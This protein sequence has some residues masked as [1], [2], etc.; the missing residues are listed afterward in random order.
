MKWC[1]P[2]HNHPPLR[3]S[4]VGRHFLMSEIQKGYKAAV[5]LLSGVFLLLD[6]YGWNGA[7]PMARKT[8]P[9]RVAYAGLGSLLTSSAFLE[10]FVRHQ[11]HD[12]RVK[13]IYT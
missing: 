12:H 3:Q 7:H 11:M 2:L 10:A 1:K 6:Y 8:A 5:F 4:K 9:A 13:V